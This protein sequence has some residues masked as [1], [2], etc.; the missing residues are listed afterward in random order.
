MSRKKN[1]TN[2]YKEQEKLRKKERNEKFF[3]KLMNVMIIV[4][5]ITLVAPVA[6]L[7]LKPDPFDPIKDGK[8]VKVAMEIKDMGTITL[9]LYA[10]LAPKTVEN[11]LKY[12]NEGFYDGVTFHRVIENFMIQ[13]GDPTGTGMGLSTAPKI[14]GEFTSNGFTNNLAFDRGV[15]GMARGDDPNSASTQ[16]FI[17]HMKSAHL[18]GEYAAFGRVIDGIEVV[19]MIATCEIDESVVDEEGKIKYKPLNDIIME[20]VY[21]IE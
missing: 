17:C 14:E 1:I 19:D 12:V 11:F 10:D 7:F 6:Y 2:Y 20:K 16:F 8:K 5:S 4:L 21:V 18:D 13:G 15:I 9:E 3:S